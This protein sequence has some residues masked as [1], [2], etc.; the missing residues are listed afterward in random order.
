MEARDDMG[1][2]FQIRDSGGTDHAEQEL[3]AQQGSSVLSES[4]STLHETHAK[5]C[6]GCEI[7]AI[8]AVFHRQLGEKAMKRGIFWTRDSTLAIIAIG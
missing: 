7:R 5:R 3:V 6:S 1:Q 2:T 8:C 4:P